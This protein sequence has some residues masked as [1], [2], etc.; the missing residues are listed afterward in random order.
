MTHHLKLFLIISILIIILSL[1][2]FNIR[3]SFSF[4]NVLI[5][6]YIIYL[7][8]KY[9]SFY[10]YS[11]QHLFLSFP[12]SLFVSQRLAGATLL[13]FANKQDLEGAANADLIR[14]VSLWGIYSSNQPPLIVL[15]TPTHYSPTHHHPPTTI[16]KPT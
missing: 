13:V 1:S 9:H 10:H 5:I 7:C 11:N 12:P 16:H 4:R 14:E 15:F 3:K 6:S 8:Y 2:Y